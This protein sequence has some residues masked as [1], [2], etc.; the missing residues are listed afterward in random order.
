MEEKKRKIIYFRVCLH[1]A[2]ERTGKK[3]LAPLLKKIKGGEL[4]A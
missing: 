1:K 2:R 3:E 4:K